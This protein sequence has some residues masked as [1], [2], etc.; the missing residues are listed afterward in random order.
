MN[1]IIVVCIS[2]VSVYLFRNFEAVVYHE[3]LNVHILKM[4]AHIQ[5][6]R[7]KQQMTQLDLSI[8][9]DIDV[10]Q[11]QRLERGHTYPSLKTFYKLHKGFNKTFEEFFREIEI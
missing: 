8:K 7:K 10:R 5:H 2:F 1:D 9:A 3:E 11:I 6:L 4:G